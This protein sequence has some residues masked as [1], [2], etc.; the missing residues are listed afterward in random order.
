MIGET[1]T[2]LLAEEELRERGAAASARHQARQP[3]VFPPTITS[4]EFD[5]GVTGWLYIGRLGEESVLNKLWL[6]QTPQ[7]LTIWIDED[8]RTHPCLHFMDRDA[9]ETNRCHVARLLL[10]ERYMV[11]VAVDE[12][13]RQ[14]I[15]LPSGESADPFIVW[16]RWQTDEEWMTAPGYQGIRLDRREHDTRDLA[17]IIADYRGN[18]WEDH[19]NLYTGDV[20]FR[21]KV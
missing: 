19:A 14:H 8:L 3:H 11:R 16:Y 13:G 1:M 5:A 7:G 18:G 21:R 12:Q 4:D 15:S 10:G 9:P 20:Y 6:K 17:A 2:G